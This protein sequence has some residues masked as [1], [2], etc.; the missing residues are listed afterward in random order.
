MANELFAHS[1]CMQSFK[2]VVTLLSANTKK[3]T[4]QKCNRKTI[5]KNIEYI[6]NE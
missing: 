5:L 1:I 3:K 4:L 6:L 2:L